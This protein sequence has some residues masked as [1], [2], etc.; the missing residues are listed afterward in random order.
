MN[1]GHVMF[2]SRGMAYGGSGRCIST[3]SSKLV[4]YGFKVSLIILRDYKSEY[5]INP[6]INVIRLGLVT[7]NIKVGIFNIITKWFPFIV[8]KSREAAPDVIIPFGVDICLLTVLGCRKKCKVCVTV[9]SNPAQEPKTVF[10]RKIRNF[11]YKKSDYIWVQNY[12]QREL[13]TSIH[14][15]KFIVIPNPVKKE[16]LQIK[17]EYSNE[18]CR[19]VNVGRL[20]AQKNQIELIKAIKLLCTKYENVQ[21]DIYGEG[22]L[23]SY[24]EKYVNDNNLQDKVFLKGRVNNISDA[25]SKEDVFI[26]NSEFEGMPNALMEAMAIGM[27][28]IS[29]D[30]ETGPRELIQNHKN[31]LLIACHNSNQLLQAMEYLI[32]H[33]QKCKEYGLLAKD[34]IQNNYDEDKVAYKLATVLE[35]M[36]AGDL[37]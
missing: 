17:F 12:Q 26:L 19:F 25:L 5:Y 10:W 27:P 2:V 34:K 7:D 32:L 35:K 1:K 9:R 31:G 11:I 23:R 6:K 37:E 33:P 24:L 21:L 28:C 29:S 36:C 4:E 15:N 8:K 13:M 16:L 18:I 14:Q 22:E 20:T 3:F 30:C